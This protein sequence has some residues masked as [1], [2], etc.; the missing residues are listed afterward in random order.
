MRSCPRSRAPSVHRLLRPAFPHVAA[1]LSALILFILM[2]GAAAQQDGFAP[3]APQSPLPRPE[4]SASEILAAIQSGQPVSYDNVTVTGSLDIGPGAGPVQGQIS[5]I[6]SRFLGPLRIVAAAFGDDLDLRGCVFEENASF[7]KSRFMGEFRLAG[8]VFLKQADFAEAVFG[9]PATFASARFLKDAS[10]SNA[11]FDGDAIFLD[12][13]FASDVDFNYAKFMRIGYFESAFFE[14]VRFFETR[15]SGQVTFRSV[16]FF[17]NAEFAATRFDSDVVFRDARFLKGSTFG[18]SSFAGIVDFGGVNFS[19]TAFLGGVKFSDL[20]YFTGTN[21]G[22][23]LI[24]EEARLYSMQLESASFAEGSTINLNSTDF[25][26]FVVH[27]P[28]IRDRLVYNGAAYLALVKNY[29]SLEWFDEAD[30]CY[31]QYRKAGQDRAAWGWGKISDIIAW[32]SCGY[33]V[34]V[35]YTAFWCLFTILFFGVIFWAGKGMSKFEIEGMELPGD[36]RLYPS[37]RVSFTDALYFSIAMF[38]TSQAPVNTYPVGV[39]RHLAMA[40]G[41]LG[42]FFLGLFVVVLSA[43]LIR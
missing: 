34:R 10:F 3:P 25:N 39:Y 32:L 28:T 43:V 2:I 35:S 16:R 21:F 8:A 17:G 33:G 20:A 30:D 12:A 22:G 5:I 37:K 18:L 36:P 23:D 38:T 27:W 29:K 11:E 26:K 42:W 7:I 1:I 4:I 24:L 9:G 41:I 19:Q 14:D 15:F 6:N 40:E 31:Y 13:G